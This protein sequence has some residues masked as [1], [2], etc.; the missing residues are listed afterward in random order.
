MAALL[1]STGGFF[2]KSVTLDAFSVSLWRSSLAAITI[3][4]VYYLNR[5]KIEPT[6]HEP[7]FNLHTLASTFFYALL[8]ILFVIATKLTTS[9]NAIFLQYTAPIY[10][11]IIEPIV[12]KTKMKSRDL[13]MVI[14]CTA[15]MALFFVG[16][17]DTKSFWG[18]IAALASGVSFALYAVLLKHERSSE[19]SRWRTVIL[20]HVLIALC[21]AAL[22]VF[23][24]TSPIPT[25][26]EFLMLLYLGVVQIGIAYSIFTFGI[27]HVR[28]IDAMLLSMV[29]PVLNPIWVFLGIGEIP[30]NYAIIGG[31]IILA[32][33]ALRTVLST[34][35][36]P[37]V[38]EYRAGE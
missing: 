37:E 32:V 18:N 30:S 29:E 1:W 15:A 36:K 20:G 7:W 8:L 31:I 22:A 14:I 4:V 21:M 25:G 10:V 17:F 38:I 27:T 28:A 5:K 19:A 13:I 11:L 9:A 16:K 24:I 3:A 33:V 26:G 34:K 12:T 35:E 23:G 6:S 2:I